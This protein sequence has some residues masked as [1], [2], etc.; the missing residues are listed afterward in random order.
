MHRL[1]NTVLCKLA[2]A[3]LDSYIN[4]NLAQTAKGKPIYTAHYILRDL[5]KDIVIV[6]ANS[7]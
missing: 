5:P 4:S 3:V 1:A 7:T 6:H 2:L